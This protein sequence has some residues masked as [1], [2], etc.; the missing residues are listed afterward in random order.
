MQFL[1]LAT[2]DGICGWVEN[3]K[4]NLKSHSNLRKTAELWLSSAKVKA[5]ERW[6]E[7]YYLLSVSS[8]SS[9][10]TSTAVLSIHKS[11]LKCLMLAYIIL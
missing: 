7:G 1:S 9:Y 2:R 11:S 5:K 3:L 6:C 4:N 8:K 10:M